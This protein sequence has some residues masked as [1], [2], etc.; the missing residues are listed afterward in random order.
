MLGVL[1]ASLVLI[2][3]AFGTLYTL[4][5]HTPRDATPAAAAAN[6]RAMAS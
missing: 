2:V 1:V 6:T 3:A 4:H 5:A